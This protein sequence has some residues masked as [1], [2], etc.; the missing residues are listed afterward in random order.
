MG[1]PV[2]P[3]VAATAEALSAGAGGER[4]VPSFSPSADSTEEIVSIVLAP[5]SSDLFL[6]GIAGLM[7][8]ALA[9]MHRH[10]LCPQWFGSVRLRNIELSTEDDLDDSAGESDS[11]RPAR[12]KKSAGKKRSWA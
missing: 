7:S 5:S 11:P 9:W 2:V 12:T 6:V 3:V 10:T 4:Q 8:A 1:S